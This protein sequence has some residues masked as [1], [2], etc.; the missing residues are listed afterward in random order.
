MDLLQWGITKS[1]HI[2]F[3]N[4]LSDLTHVRN[5]SGLSKPKSMSMLSLVFHLDTSI[6]NLTF[7]LIQTTSIAIVETTQYSLVLSSEKS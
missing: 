2:N 5:T 4:S 6:L 7:S 3:S 1:H